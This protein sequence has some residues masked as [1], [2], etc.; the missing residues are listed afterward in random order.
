MADDEDY[1]LMHRAPIDDGYS[2]PVTDALIQFGPDVLD[3]PDLY[4]Q[5]DDETVRQLHA[6]VADP[7]A[8]V[9]IYRAV[10]PAFLE[11]N[12]GD[13]VTLSRAYAH[14]HGYQDDPG[15]DWPI[16]Y[17]DVPA[18]SVWTDGND[19]SEYGYDGPR[20]Q[21]L[22]PYHEH[23]DMPDASPDGPSRQSPPQTGAERLETSTK[24]AERTPAAGSSGASVQLRYNEMW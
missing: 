13:W 16:V 20:L 1:R 4:G 22:R 2:R 15:G 5:A 14:Q 10:P 12:P 18:T 6:A 8:I 9:R 11:I 21:G 17:A 23:D 3:R 19:P 7:R 24:F